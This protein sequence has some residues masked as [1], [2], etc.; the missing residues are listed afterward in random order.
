VSFVRSLAK[1][2]SRAPDAAPAW[3]VVGLGNPGAQYAK[4]RHNIGFV[5]VNRLAQQGHTR[6]RTVA[7]DRAD[8][9]QVTIGAVPVLLVQPVTY[10]N[11][12]GQAVSR[13]VKRYALDPLH[14]L[15]IYDDVD[16]PFPAVRIRQEG[17]SGGHRGVQSVVESLRS[18]AIPRVRIGIGR[19]PGSTKDYVLTEF[20]SDERKQIL[21]LADH[22]ASIVEKIIGEGVV[23]AMNQFNGK[24]VEGV[25][26]A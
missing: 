21:V 13:L 10:M 3:L 18:T 25:T 8:V 24:P 19:G 26:T 17:S 5:C 1:L 9:A 6:F 2:R 15:L 22:V 23:E 12:S 20:S 4:T 11:E 14:V 7:R 16:L